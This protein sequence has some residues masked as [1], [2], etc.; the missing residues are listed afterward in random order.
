[1]IDVP[2]ND[3]VKHVLLHYKTML[4]GMTA[5]D[6]SSSE[7]SPESHQLNL[8]ETTSAIS[9]IPCDWLPASLKPYMARHRRTICRAFSQYVF[10]L[11]KQLEEEWKTENAMLKEYFVNQG[12]KWKEPPSK[13]LE[14]EPNLERQLRAEIA[15][16]S[17]LGREF[18]SPFMPSDGKPRIMKMLTDK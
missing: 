15:V 12:L 9:E 10:D 3:L 6:P 1:M 14:I 4:D 11:K 13:K 17:K 16:V 18:C 8:D 5:Y 2:I 7:Y